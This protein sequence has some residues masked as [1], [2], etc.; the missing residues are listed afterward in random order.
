MKVTER[1][2]AVT[3]STTWLL[4]RRGVG[5]LTYDYAYT[6][7]PISVREIGVRVLLEPACDEIVWKRWSEWAVYPE[8]SISRIEGRAKAR[9]TPHYDPSEERFRP[10]WPWALDQTELG[11]NDFRA[12]KL[13][14]REAVLLSPRGEGLRVCANADAHVRACLDPAGVKLHLLSECRLR[15]VSLKP[16]D[17]LRGRFAVELLPR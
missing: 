4:D 12:V 10:T 2:D 6:G 13:N 5:T 11:T 7:Q 14:I 16:G 3:G 8:D 9:R 1:F 17:R 15:P